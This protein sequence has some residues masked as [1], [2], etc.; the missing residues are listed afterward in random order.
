MINK[1]RLIIAI[2]GAS[3]VIYGIRMVEVLSSIPDIEMHLIISDSAKKTIEI[4]TDYKISEIE[5]MADVLHDFRDIGSPI[6][7]GSFLTEGMVIIPCTIKTMSAI[8]N[9]YTDNLIIRAADVCLKERRRLILVVRETPLHLG[10][11]RT[12]V[13]LTEM[14]AII[15]PPIPSFYHFPK[16]INDIIDQTV[17]KILDLFNIHVDL[18]KRWNNK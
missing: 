3:G 4:E 13:N 9:S 10:H 12:M 16:T 11:L 6:A 7:S 2:T 14:G 5:R 18:F 8:A 1:R 15:F 17:G